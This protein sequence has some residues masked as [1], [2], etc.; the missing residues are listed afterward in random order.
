MNSDITKNRLSREWP[1]R[2]S[3]TTI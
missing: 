1:F 2:Y 3:R